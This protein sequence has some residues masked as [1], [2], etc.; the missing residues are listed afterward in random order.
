[1]G[2]GVEGVPR[3]AGVPPNG[4]RQLVHGNRTGD[5][6]ID[7]ERGPLSLVAESRFLNTVEGELQPAK[8]T[9][10][11]LGVSTQRWFAPEDLVANEDGSVAL[12]WLVPF[13]ELRKRWGTT[14][15]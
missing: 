14:H 10:S 11:E 4:S 9:D 5:G 6:K 8:G 2:G 13:L 12:G 15:S 3:V 7:Q 1:M